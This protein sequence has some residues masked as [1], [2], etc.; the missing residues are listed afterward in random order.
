MNLGLLSILTSE[1]SSALNESSDNKCESCDSITY[2]LFDAEMLV[3]HLEMQG[4]WSCQTALA[5]AEEVADVTAE[6]EMD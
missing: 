3:A 5:F 4:T 6:G 1:S 2:V